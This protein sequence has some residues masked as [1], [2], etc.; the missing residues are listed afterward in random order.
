MIYVDGQCKYIFPYIL[1]EY[2]FVIDGR[3][4]TRKL[5]RNYALYYQLFLWCG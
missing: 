2:L 3:E 1:A 4:S 5:S